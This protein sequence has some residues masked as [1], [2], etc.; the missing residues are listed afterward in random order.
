[1]ERLTW[2]KRARRWEKNGFR[3]WQLSTRDNRYA[4]QRSEYVANDAIFDRVLAATGSKPKAFAA[5]L[6][7]TYRALVSDDAGETWSIIS[8]HRK[9]IPARDACQKHS[10]RQG[11]L[12]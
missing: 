12:T 5:M 2:R 3:Y 8:K 7:D 11:A 9:L 6:P 10:N 4:I 1:M